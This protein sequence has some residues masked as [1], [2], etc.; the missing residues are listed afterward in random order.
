[1]YRVAVKKLRRELLI[2]RTA[3]Q[4]VKIY[5]DDEKGFRDSSI[6]STNTMNT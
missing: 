2:L 1:M 6:R 5:K 3:V 4:N